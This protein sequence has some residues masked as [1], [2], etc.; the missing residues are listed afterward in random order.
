MGQDPQDRPAAPEAQ[1]AAPGA[2][3]PRVL[4]GRERRRHPRRPLLTPATL[5][6]VDGVNAGA[7][8]EIQ[9]RDLSLSGLC[10]LLRES[11]AVGQSCRITLP[12]EGTHLCEVIRCRL[13]S[14]GKYEVGVQFRKLLGK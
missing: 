8:Y 9:T 12:S 6:V 4:D 3:A 13:L 1:P 5:T 14:N 10:F 11:L 2:P 7:S